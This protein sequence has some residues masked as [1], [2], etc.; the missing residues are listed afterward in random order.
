M[1]VIITGDR[2]WRCDSLAERVVRSLAERHG[3]QLTIR[4]GACEGV[5]AAFDLACLTLRV[6][7]Q[8]Y[9]AD[10]S[11]G[12][13]AGPVRNSAMVDA[14]AGL[15]LAFHRYIRQS[16]GT[17]DCTCKAIRAG[18]PTWLVESEDVRPVRLNADDPRL[19]DWFKRYG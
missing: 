14:G 3:D 6:D 19:A 18:I 5:D 7:R 8:P 2:H 11:L 15:C 13:R 17:K 9:P 16:K 4:H 12:N 1:T 10:W